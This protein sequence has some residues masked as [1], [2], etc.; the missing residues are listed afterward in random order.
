MDRRPNFMLP[1]LAFELIEERIKS[2]MVILELGSGDGSIRLDKKYEL[3]SIEHD[4]DWAKNHPGTCI[5]CDIV[6]NPS[7]QEVG[8]EG[9]YAIEPEEPRI[10][11][12]IDLLLVDGP[13]GWIGRTGLIHHEWL[14]DRCEHF[15]IDDTDR[16][17]EYTLA[18][19]I[20]TM[21]NGYIEDF[22]ATELN[23]EGM[24]RR[25]TWIRRLNE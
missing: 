7:S 3:I 19:K 25:F 20:Q 4:L 9:W 24:P 16:P 14:L 23:G 21:T 18:L 6:S 5:Q 17:A 2:G 15:L 13:P 8:E 10:P 22:A 1:E 11:R 12:K